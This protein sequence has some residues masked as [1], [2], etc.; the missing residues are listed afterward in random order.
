VLQEFRENGCASKRLVE[1]A[2]CGPVLDPALVAR[3][4]EHVPNIVVR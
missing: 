3:L 1:L 2:R 4:G